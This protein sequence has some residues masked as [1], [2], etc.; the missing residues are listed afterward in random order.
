ML[1]QTTPETNVQLNGGLSSISS[2]VGKAS[3]MSWLIEAVPTI[4]LRAWVHPLLHAVCAAKA[5]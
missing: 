5:D 3:F 2:H 4:C 1:E